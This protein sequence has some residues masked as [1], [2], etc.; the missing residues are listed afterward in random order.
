MVGALVVD[1]AGEVAG[2][3]WH[4][5]AGG[6]HAEV[7]ALRRAG[8]RARGGT[9][10]VTLEPCCTHGRTP[11]CTDAIIRAGIRRVVVGATDPNPAHS[12]RGFE[13]LRRAGIEVV[14]GVLADECEDL[15]LIFNHWIAKGTPLLAIKAATTLCGSIATR[16]GDSRW[17]T[18][19]EARADVHRWRRLFPAIA[20]GSGTILAD[21]PQLTSRLDA[22]DVFCPVRFVF[23]GRLRTVTDPL[24][25]LYCDEFRERTCVV[26]GRDAPLDSIDALRIRGVNVLQ[27]PAGAEIWPAFREHCASVGLTGVL[28]EGG[29]RLFESLLRAGQADYLFAYRAPI[30]FADSSAL[31]AFNGCAPDRVSNALRL[32]KVRHAAFGDDMLTRGY[33]GNR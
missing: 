8:E 31:P 9:L 10:Y 29:A 28:V 19:A 18:G 2:E 12:G 11:P 4:E 6:P 27:L 22:N 32:E 24:P 13:I 15:N 17:I 30:L 1:A 25:R 14:E 20:V 26:T 16:T 5:K 3:G 23:D 7:F 33:I 21:D